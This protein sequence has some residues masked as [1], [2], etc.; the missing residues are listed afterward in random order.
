MKNPATATPETKPATRPRGRPGLTDQNREAALQAARDLLAESGLPGLQARAIAGRAG[1]SVGSIYKLFGDIEALVRTLNRET[2]REFA[3]HHSAALAEL[4]P[5]ETDVMVPLMALARAYIDFV[6]ANERRWAAVLQTSQ[7]RAGPRPPDYS[8]SENALFA[9][10]E[11]VIEGVPGFADPALR[12]RAARAMWASVHG[13]VTITLPN[14]RAEDP[15]AD[16]MS[17]IELIIG[18]VIRDAGGAPQS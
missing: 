10:V 7:R 8:Q 5:G 15:A 11:T 1:L 16:T 12:A 17:Q 9:I 4:D 13:I 14:S 3:A 2:H 6:I 18:A